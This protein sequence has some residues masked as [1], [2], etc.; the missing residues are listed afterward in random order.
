VP[1]NDFPKAGNGEKTVCR[2]FVSKVL[3]IFV[4][5]GAVVVNNQQTPKL[6]NS[7]QTTKQITIKNI[8][9]PDVYQHATVGR[10]MPDA[11][12][13]PGLNKIGPC[14]I[15]MQGEVKR[16]QRGMF[17]DE[18]I[19][20][21]TDGLKRLLDKQPF[22][23]AVIGFLT[24]GNRFYFIRCTRYK[25]DGRDVYETSSIFKEMKGWQVINVF[26]KYCMCLNFDLFFIY[27]FCL[28]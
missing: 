1:R 20:Q 3:K 23:S 22:R 4:N 6:R 19:G 28:V 5:G 7:P 15:V 10:K 9:D 25:D 14:A 27:R 21:L 16:C 12:F 17:P 11:V 2:P 26:L 18:E 8:P 24:D 13:Y